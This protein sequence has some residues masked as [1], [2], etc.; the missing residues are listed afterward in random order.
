MT[1]PIDAVAPRP[2]DHDPRAHWRYEMAR[3][4]RLHQRGP[5]ADPGLDH[6]DRTAAIY[7]A[8][9]YLKVLAALD[10][11]AAQ[12]AVGAVNGHLMDGA[13]E[14]ADQ[15]LAETGASRDDLD[16]MYAH[17]HE[18]KRARALPPEPRGVV[19]DPTRATAAEVAAYKEGFAHGYNLATARHDRDHPDCPHPVP[20]APGEWAITKR[21]EET[22]T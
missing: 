22:P 11:Q 4:L 5:R 14:W 21:K 8:A 17:V 9:Y 15:Y 3:Y 2:A 1:D 18:Q 13:A 20:L 6:F 12:A 7:T 19:M 16:A 10:P